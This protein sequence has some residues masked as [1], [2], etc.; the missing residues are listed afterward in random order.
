ML[1]SEI[2]SECKEQIKKY[3][4]G[5][6]FFWKEY[7]FPDGTGSK[8]SYI[9]FLTSYVREQF[10]IVRGTSNTGPYEIQFGKRREFFRITPDK[11][12]YLTRE[13]ILDFAFITSLPQEKLAAAL[14]TGTIKHIGKISP[15]II[16]QLV[17]A[18]TSAKTVE[19]WKKQEIKQSK[20][21]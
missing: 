4:K 13:T 10:L 7:R 17:N 6:I 12:P 1:Q 11:C 18:V 20:I 21:A 15:E 8:D 14:D 5:D 3:G 19:R 2:S 9:I 16:V